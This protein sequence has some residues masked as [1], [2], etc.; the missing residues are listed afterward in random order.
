MAEMPVELAPVSQWRGERQSL[1]AE[2][3]RK[4]PKHSH[5][6]VH[7]LRASL[8]FFRR[9]VAGRRQYHCRGGRR[10]F[11]TLK[12]KG[13]LERLRICSPP[14]YSPNSARGLLSCKHCR[15]HRCLQIGMQIDG[16]YDALHLNVMLT[17]RRSEGTDRARRC[18]RSRRLLNR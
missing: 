9:T 14:N 15:F 1:R 2:K 13:M 16:E 10:C 17:C 6:F 18:L 12:G 8:A 11:T 7:K 3:L 5:C 4:Q